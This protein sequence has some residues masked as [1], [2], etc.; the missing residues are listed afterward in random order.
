MIEQMNVAPIPKRYG[1]L[2]V[3]NRHADYKLQTTVDLD[4]AR[5]GVQVRLEGELN[6]DQLLEASRALQEEVWFRSIQP[7]SPGVLIRTHYRCGIGSNASIYVTLL[8]RQNGGSSVR[9]VF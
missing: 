5:F 1:L 6:Q 2:G 9:V 7:D 8:A 3:V 4:F